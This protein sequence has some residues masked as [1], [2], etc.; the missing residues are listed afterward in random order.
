M[1]E[2]LRP[3]VMSFDF[4]GVAAGGVGSS[5]SPTPFHLEKSSGG[6]M[7]DCTVCE[8]LAAAVVPVNSG[9]SNGIGAALKSLAV[10]R[11]EISGG[12]CG[13]AG[14]FSS[15][16][17]VHKSLGDQGVLFLMRLEL[18]TAFYG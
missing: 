9:L 10:E 3:Y 17:Q 16:W 15:T 1:P 14:D 2:H 12:F 7:H 18:E 8:P 11:V 6:F 13:K 4:L 5:F